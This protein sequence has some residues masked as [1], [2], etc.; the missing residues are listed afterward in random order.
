MSEM[1]SALRRE[2]QLNTTEDEER[3]V[4][5]VIGSSRRRIKFGAEVLKG[6]S[7][8]TATY[9]NQKTVYLMVGTY[10]KIIN[11]ITQLKSLSSI[12]WHHFLS[13]L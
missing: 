12:F 5:E 2:K 1:Q 3:G 8:V 7:A 6:E 9:N 4:T 10:R 13:L 11:R